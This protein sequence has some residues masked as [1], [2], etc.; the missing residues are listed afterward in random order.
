MKI[1]IFIPFLIVIIPFS[2]TVT[3]GQSRRDSLGFNE[4]YSIWSGS[5]LEK[6][7]QQLLGLRYI[8]TVYYRHIFRNSLKFDVDASVNAYCNLEF[9]DFHYDSFTARAKPY[10]LSARISG[11]QW[12]I[13]GGL[14]KISFGSST[15]LRPLMW[16]DQLDPRD[17]LQLTDGV[18]GLLGRYYFLNNANIWLWGLAGNSERRG[19]DAVPPFPRKPEFGGRIQIPLFK[20]ETAFSFNHRTALYEGF[21]YLSADSIRIPETRIGLDGKWDA[22]PGIWYEYV[23]KRTGDQNPGLASEEHFL[24]LGSDYTFGIGN[25]LNITGEH[26][27]YHTDARYTGGIRSNNFTALI[28]SYPFG[29]TDRASLMVY[30]NYENKDWY[31]F[32]SLQRQYDKLSVYLMFFINPANFNIYSG[33]SE[34]NRFGGTGFQVMLT[35]NN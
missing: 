31:R 12:E 32:L 17:P 29:M 24:S 20:G 4:Q 5:N 15:V 22:G 18:Y 21:G 25:G 2:A 30:Y 35:Y 13:R 27:Y 14:Q 9:K 6:P 33:G 23:Y 28:L 7:S 19:W 8:Q 10:R 11:T 34:M 16:F 26:L 3:E 1:K